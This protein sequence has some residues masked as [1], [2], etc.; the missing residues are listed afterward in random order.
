[1]R[2]QSGEW[3]AACISSGQTT[4]AQAGRL[5]AAREILGEARIL[6]RLQAR[7]PW[8]GP[9]LALPVTLPPTWTHGDKKKAK[10][11]KSKDVAAVPAVDTPAASPAV[12]SKAEG[13]RLKAKA[14]Q[15]PEAPE[16]AALVAA[17]AAAEELS[18][19]DRKRLKK[20]AKAQKKGTAP[21]EQEQEAPAAAN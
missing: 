9:A 2:R 19:A 21:E 6:L 20:E 18:K 10:K 3:W 14:A 15:A 11:S 13:K 12:V 7:H 1:M 4:R 8:L 5:A 16:A 17:P